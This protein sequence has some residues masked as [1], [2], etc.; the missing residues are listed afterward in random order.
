MKFFHG[1]KLVYINNIIIFLILFEEYLY[2]LNLIFK[3]LSNINIY[4]V[5][6]KAYLDYLLVYLLG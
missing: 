1:P 6:S 2:Y 3:V 4:L 5:L